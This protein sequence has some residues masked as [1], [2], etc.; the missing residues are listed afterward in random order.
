MMMTSKPVNR[1]DQLRLIVD[2][3]SDIN[4]ADVVL[5]N[6]EMIRWIDI[7]FIDSIKTNKKHPNLLLI[8]VTS[9]GDADV[10]YRIARCAQDN[11]ERFLVFVSGY[12]KS[13]GTLCVMGA[14]E[15]I[16]CDQ[17]E[18]GPLDVQFYKKDELGELNSG[19]VIEEALKTLTHKSEI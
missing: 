6:S 14:H 16:M 4:K 18:L 13:A 9:G 12:C 7:H 2:R 5:F 17:G 3:V 19:L 15:I 11:Y 10:A 1:E 8:L